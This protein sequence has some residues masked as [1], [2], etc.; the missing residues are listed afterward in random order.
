MLREISLQ[1]HS[2]ACRAR[3][4][5]ASEGCARVE[6]TKIRLRE[7][8]GRSEAEKSEGEQVQTKRRKLEDIEGNAMEEEDPSKLAELFEEYH[9]ESARA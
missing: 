5:K 7:R 9:Q 8:V 1:P 3:M 2:R 4:E 6:H